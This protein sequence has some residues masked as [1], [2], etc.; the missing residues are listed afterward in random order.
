MRLDEISRVAIQR[1]LSR[2]G[3]AFQGGTKPDFE[4]FT[5]EVQ[6]ATRGWSEAELESAITVTIQ[7]CTYFPRV[8]HIMDA[9]PMTM[10]APSAE[11]VNDS[12]C[13]RCGV[14]PYAGAYEN[15]LGHVSARMRCACDPVLPG[16]STP[17]AKAADAEIRAK[18]DADVEK[19][20]NRNADLR[21]A[22]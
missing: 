14:L 8:K 22:A 13:R 9:R 1:Q 12:H 17:A 11:P 7:T 10:R 2:L 4:R 6:L 19:G 18:Y 16:W 21:W 20:A 5:G 15:T 3:D